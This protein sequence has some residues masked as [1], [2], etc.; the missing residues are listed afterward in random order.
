[1]SGS[2]WGRVFRLTTFGESHGAALGGIID[3]CPAGL[4][5]TPEFI[6]EKLNARKARDVH[7][8]DGLA[9]T[10]RKEPDKVQVLSGLFEGHTT[11]TPIGFIIANEDV[12]ST[13][14]N[15]LA[16]A[17]RPGHADISYTAKYGVRDHRGGG[18]ASSRE[19]ACRVVGG[20]VAERLLAAEGIQ[21]YA[22]A[23]ELGGIAINEDHYQMEKAK[24]NPFFAAHEEIVPQWQELVA[25]ARNENDSLGGIVRIVARHVPAGLGEPV[26]QKLDAQ[27]AAAL[28]SVGAVKGI[29][30]GSGFTSARMRG[31]EHNDAIMPSGRGE[32]HVSFDRNV[33][34]VFMS[35]HAG[36]ILGGLSSGQEIVLYAA[37]KP[38]PSIAMEQMSINSKG[39]PVCLQIQGRHDVCAIPRIVPVLASMTALTLADAV[40]L[41]KRMDADG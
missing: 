16:Q 9:T 31:S 17:F 7:A 25:D 14:Y 27:L 4:P 11:G 18:R 38:I 40:L 8:A 26:F 32:A 13:D 41:Q 2:T 23:V 36:G 1:M 39:E 24:N 12:R 29:E 22:A 15:E 5:L 37:I 20:A 30:I 21:I 34:G 3:G 33:G 6:Q 19:T 10:G 28:M 35:N